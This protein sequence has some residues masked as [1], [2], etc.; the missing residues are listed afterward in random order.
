MATLPVLPLRNLVLLPGAVQA[1]DVGRPGSLK[2]VEQVIAAPPARLL[3]ATQK[4]PKNDNP[5]PSDLHPIAV[6][7]E[8]L[9]VVRLDTTRLSLVVRVL[10]RR[11]LGGFAQTQP[12]LI[13]ETVPTIETNVSGAEVE[14]LAM[15]V[16]D[17]AKQL[18][19]RTPD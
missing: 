19:T 9:K 6:E 16:R 14:G 5:S 7:A 15:A 1:V 4:D 10:G 3:L 12:Y 13:A 8:I 17:A 11:G 2:L 18:V